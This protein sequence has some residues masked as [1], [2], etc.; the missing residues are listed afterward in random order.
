MTPLIT[1]N[2]TTFVLR[3]ISMNIYY[4]E[5]TYYDLGS[6]ISSIGGFFSSLSGIFVFLFGASKLAPW[7][8]L[9]IYVFN[10][11]CIRYQRKLAKKLKSKY[12]PIPFISGRTKNF[13]LEERIQSME[14]LLEE[15]YLDTNFL[16]LLIEENNVDDKV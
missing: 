5:E 2:V 12:E 3:P 1:P 7:G 13:T 8:F 10:C 15:Y 11:L 16:N 9:Q 6:I 14:N 4:Q